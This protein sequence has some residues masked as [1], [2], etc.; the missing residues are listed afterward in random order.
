M[1]LYMYATREPYSFLV[2]RLGAKTWEG[3]CWLRFERRLKV[4]GD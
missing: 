1:E 4:N 2:V 3:M